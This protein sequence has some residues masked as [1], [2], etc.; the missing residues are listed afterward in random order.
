MKRNKKNSCGYFN[1]TCV[2]IASL[3]PNMTISQPSTEELNI[4]DLDNYKH[5]PAALSGFVYTYDHILEPEA[6]DTSVAIDDS[7]PDVTDTSR[8]IESMVPEIKCIPTTQLNVESTTEAGIGYIIDGFSLYKDKANTKRAQDTELVNIETTP[9][10]FKD[11]DVMEPSILEPI[12]LLPSFDTP[13]APA[14]PSVYVPSLSY[15]LEK[16]I[17]A[18]TTTIVDDIGALKRRLDGIE[19][20]VS[21]NIRRATEAAQRSNTCTDFEISL[22][23]GSSIVPD[24]SG[25]SARPSYQVAGGTVL[26]NGKPHTL[27]GLSGLNPPFIVHIV[28]R[29]TT[30]AFSLALSTSGSGNVME[31][32]GGVSETSFTQ[33]I[34]GK[35]ESYNMYTIH[36]HTCAPSVTYVP[37]DAAGVVVYT[38]EDGSLSPYTTYPTATCDEDEG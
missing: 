28:R 2:G 14:L 26:V 22:S 27:K 35:T 17:S 29:D 6:T 31:T 3:S 23:S 34:N 16:T 11:S 5:I 30:S 18:I 10:S 13:T 8:P 37:L 20:K 4:G 38:G 15:F 1:N 24:E 7:E 9:L 21:S 36:Q 25:S 32:I 12:T 19:A 33:V